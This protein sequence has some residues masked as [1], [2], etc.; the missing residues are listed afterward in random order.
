MHKKR[1]LLA[2]PG[3]DGHDKGVRLVAMALRDAG[4]EVIYLGLRQ[5]AQSIVQ[6][7]EDENVD[8]IGLSI[9]SGSHLGISEKVVKLIN[10]QM[11]EPHPKLIV[12]GT[13]PRE[14]INRLKETGVSHVFPVGTSFAAIIAEL[15]DSISKEGE[16]N[17]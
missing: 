1:I 2:K 7:A 9:L 16:L 10:E 12:G 14:D 15:T 11:P 8:L 13:I 6:A 3:L 4:Y 5:T 17:G